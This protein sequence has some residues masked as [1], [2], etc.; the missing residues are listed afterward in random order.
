MSQI[1]M[2]LLGLLAALPTG[3]IGGHQRTGDRESP[4][5]EG[6]W[7]IVSVERD[8]RPDALQIGARMTFTGDTVVFTPNV[9][10]VVDGLS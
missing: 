7:E 2:A 9:V 6:A 5:L 10:D 1:R 4:S 3:C 8:G